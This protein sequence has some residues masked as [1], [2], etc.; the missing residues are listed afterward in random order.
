MIN[1]LKNRM[2][3]TKSKQAIHVIAVFIISIFSNIYTLRI[4]KH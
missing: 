2:K 4:K 3:F 1:Y